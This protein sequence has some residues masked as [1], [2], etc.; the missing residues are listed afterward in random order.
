MVLEIASVFDKKESEIAKLEK[1]IESLKAEIKAK[2]ELFEEYMG[3]CPDNLF[4]LANFIDSCISN[5]DD[6]DRW[7]NAFEEW[8]D[9]MPTPDL[10]KQT[11]NVKKEVDYYNAKC[12]FC[13]GPAYETPFSQECKNK[14]R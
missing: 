11:P 8:Q 5:S 14:C 7:N 4:N 10:K 3:G 12:Y 2:N 1:E 6:I 13:G 9:S